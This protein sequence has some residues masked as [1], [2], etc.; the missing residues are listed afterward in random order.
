MSGA[1]RIRF[2][3]KILGSHRDYWVAAGALNEPEET[4]SDPAIEKRGSGVNHLVYWVTDNLLGD[5]IQLPDCNP[6]HIVA[7]R[8]IKHIMTGD[9]NA[10]VNSNPKFPGKE[11]HFLRA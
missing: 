11:R 5:W 1:D 3:G 4:N 6:S 2:A 8:R 9:L 10:E 7:A